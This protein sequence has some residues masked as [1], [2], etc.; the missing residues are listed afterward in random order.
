MGILVERYREELERASFPPLSRETLAGARAAF[1]QMLGSSYPPRDVGTVIDHE[2]PSHNRSR[3]VR[4]RVYSRPVAPGPSILFFHGGGFVLGSLE[5]HDGFCRQLA[6]LSGL[7]V[8]SVDYALAPEHPYPAALEDARA[9]AEW[10]RVNAGALNIDPERV[11]VMG[12]SAGGFLATQVAAGVPAI[13]LQV[14]LYPAL[15]FTASSASHRLFGSGH[16]LDSETIA[17]CY[18]C[19]LNGTPASAPGLSPGLAS[20]SE[21]APAIIAVAEADPLRDEGV[22]Y[23]RLLNRHGRGAALWEIPDAVHGFCA[24]PAQFPQAEQVLARLADTLRR[25]FATDKTEY[26]SILAGDQ[27]IR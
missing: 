10:M 27:A 24:H 1:D 18:D 23:A 22:A 4:L 6:A 8:L 16:G 17:F 7:V 20:L 9:A 2:I 14:L 5:S 3:P 25:V 21:A 13:A 12:D 15:D 19:F 11:V 26:R